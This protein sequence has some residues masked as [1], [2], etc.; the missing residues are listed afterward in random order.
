MPVALMI[1]FAIVPSWLDDIELPF[2]PL[3]I[4]DS[5]AEVSV[6]CETP[7]LV[8]SELRLVPFDTAC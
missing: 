1:E 8:A 3:E 2:G 7:L 6:L 5:T 4:A